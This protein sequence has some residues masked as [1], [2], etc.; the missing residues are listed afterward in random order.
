MLLPL[1]PVFTNSSRGGCATFGSIGLSTVN[2][3]GDNSSSH[4][5]QIS[6]F[7]YFFF[8][9]I[10]H[11]LF[12]VDAYYCGGLSYF[13]I[14]CLGYF[15][16]LRFCWLDSPT[17]FTNCQPFPFDFVIVS[18]IFAVGYEEVLEKEWVIFPQTCIRIFVSTACETIGVFFLFLTMGSESEFRMWSR[19]FSGVFY[20]G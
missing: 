19:I 1:L 7:G 13:V 12:V 6:S 16:G 10:E 3:G 14:T 4:F 11:L 15:M 18:N 9:G 17:T 20:P 8:P 2:C 5:F